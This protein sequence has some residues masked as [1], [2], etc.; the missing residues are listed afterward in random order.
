MAAWTDFVRNENCGNG[1][2]R[3]GNTSHASTRITLPKHSRAAHRWLS[4]R[5]SEFLAVML[6]TLVNLAKQAFYGRP[7][8]GQGGRDE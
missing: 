4:P 7:F 6:E 5:L 8:V 3:S 1:I 2:L